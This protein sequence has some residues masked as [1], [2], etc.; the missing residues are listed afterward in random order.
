MDTITFELAAEELDQRF[1]ESIKA[2][3]KGNKIVITVASKTKQ[4]KSDIGN[5]S[6]VASESK[7]SYH[8]PADVFANLTD[9]V[10]EDETFDIMSEFRKYK[11]EEE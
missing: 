7:V 6:D 8:I 5:I 11:V 10:F 2:L 3:F 4:Y 1:V 9:K